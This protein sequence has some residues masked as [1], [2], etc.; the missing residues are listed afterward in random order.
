MPTQRYSTDFPNQVHQLL[1]TVSRHLYVL[2]NGE[3]HYQK[4]PFEVDLKNVI[5][6]SKVHIV[7]YILK[8]HYSGLFYA[9][10]CTQ[11][12]LISIEEFLFRAWSKKDNF[13][14]CGMP[15][16]LTV[17]KSVIDF[18]PGLISLL[19]AL[20]ISIVEPTSGYQAGVREIRTWENEIRIAPAFKPMLK[21][22]DALKNSTLEIVRNLNSS[23]G[24]KSKIS[25]WSAL[26]EKVYLPTDLKAFKEYYS[27]EISEKVRK[28]YPKLS[29]EVDTYDTVEGRFIWG[30]E[31][32]DLFDRFYD[33]EEAL[34]QGFEKRGK[35]ELKRIIEEDPEFIDAYNSLGFLE[36]SRNRYDKALKLFQQAYKI[37]KN[38][39]PEDFTG[40]LIWGVL[41][42][43]PFLRAMHGLGVCYLETGELKA[44]KDIFLTMLHYNPNDNQGI[45]A[46]EIQSNLALEQYS[47]V[48]SIC[49]EYPDDTMTD[50]LYGRALALYRIGKLQ[51]A[52]EALKEAITYLPL[53]AKEL[54]KR[55][56]TPVYGSMPGTIT[57]GGA[58]EAYEYWQR[59]GK[60]WSKTEDTLDFVR[61]V[62]LLLKK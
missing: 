24:Q 35:S 32:D 12:D 28:I 42:N 16:L 37:G 50:T 13:A 57:H 39:I 56:H 4:K 7:H 22:F 18:A 46:L 45:R 29:F 40:R 44:A 19:N 21:S 33:A 9:E 23:G 27:K 51:E 55:Q 20:Q 31:R 5:K 17:P 34:N 1:I 15:V 14:F 10:L 58:D 25:K 47:E 2:K 36:I 30:N 49:A 41:D 53:V 11:H 60:Y 52:E 59:V 8:D 6:S 54:I 48:L 3:V 26:I 62:L 43:R 38:V 61:N